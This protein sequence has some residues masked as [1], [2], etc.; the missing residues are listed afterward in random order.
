MLSEQD[1]YCQANYV[2]LLNFCSY[3]SRDVT[4]SKGKIIHRGLFY[5]FELEALASY[6]SQKEKYLSPF[7]APP[8]LYKTHLKE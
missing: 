6:G 5:M 7:H 1:V 2:V 3:N 4:N 8:C